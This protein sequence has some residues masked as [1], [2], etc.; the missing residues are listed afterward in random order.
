MSSFLRASSPARVPQAAASALQDISSG[1]QSAQ[2]KPYDGPGPEAMGPQDVDGL[3]KWTSMGSP[4]D[5]PASQVPSGVPLCTGLTDWGALEELQWYAPCCPP[6]CPYLYHNGRQ[7]EDAIS[8]WTTP[9]PKP[10]SWW[11]P[12]A[13]PRPE[14]AVFGHQNGKGSIPAASGA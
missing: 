10:L 8:L 6:V 7:V 13:G 1:L 5:R 2:D 14:T 12:T 3:E 11:Q 9:R 4:E